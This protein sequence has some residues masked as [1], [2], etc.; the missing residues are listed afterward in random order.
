MTSIRNLALAARLGGAFGVLCVAMAIVAFTGVHS[1]NGLRAKSDELVER[2]LRA[3]EL[4][5]GIQTRTKDNV[6]LVAQ[7][8]YVHDGD[9]AAQDR[10][11]EDIAT[12]WD[13][14]RKAAVELEKLFKGTS[15]E[16]AYVD[17][18]AQRTDFVKLQKTS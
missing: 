11:A 5:G 6:S 2:H 10:L 17:F 18:A 1:M 14:N 3:A 8:L 9:L 4:L 13:A 15:A 12:N 16:D 7:H